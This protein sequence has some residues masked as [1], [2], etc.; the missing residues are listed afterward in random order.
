M[1]IRRFSRAYA[2]SP[3]GIASFLAALAA[4]IAGSLIGLRPLLAAALCALVFVAL[5]ALGLAFGV[6]QRAAVSESG[7]A[8]RAAAGERLAE[9]AEARR[10]LAALRISDHSIAQARDLVV[11]ETGRLVEDC[12]RAGTYD[13]QAV[14]AAIDALGLVDAWQ[15]E[16][17]SSAV[18]RRF[19]LPDADPFPDAAGR[20]AASLRE[21]AALI[22]SRRAEALG[23]APPS[24]RLSIEEELK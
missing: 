24:D 3:I 15:K 18:E 11:L 1:D 2:R 6:A 16:A 17:D 8:D 21:K 4:G 20:T 5:A 22:A 7:R 10:R 12:G 19:D 23:E 13:P 9:A 14:Q